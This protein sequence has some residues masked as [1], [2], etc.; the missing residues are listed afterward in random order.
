[1]K[2]TIIALFMALL[3]LSVGLIACS[4]SAEENKE[5]GHVHEYVWE[6][7]R[8]ATCTAE[9]ERTGTCALDGAT[10]TERLEKIAHTPANAVIENSIDATCNIEGSYDEVVY[11]S[12]CGGELSRVKKTVEKIAHTPAAAVIENEVPATTTEKGSYDEVVYCSVCGE[13]LQ[14]ITK[15]TEVLP[16]EEDGEE[17]TYDELKELFN[18]KK[19]APYTKVEIE[20]TEEDTTSTAI[21]V[22]TGGEWEKLEMSDNIVW[23]NDF[24]MY[25]FTFS[26]AALAQ[27]ENID[28]S[29]ML[30]IYK[31]EDGK[32]KLDV[33]MYYEDQ[34]QRDV[35]ILDEFFYVVD[36]ARYINGEPYAFASCVWS[37]EEGEEITY[38]EL[39]ELFDN[40]ET[41]NYIRVDITYADQ[42]GSM[43]P[44]S[45]VFEFIDEEWV[46]SEDPDGVG[47]AE[48]AVSYYIVKEGDLD[49]FENFPAGGTLEILKFSNGNIKITATRVQQGREVFVTFTLDKYFYFLD[50]LQTVN[51][52]KVIEFHG[53]WFSDEG[54]EITF[55]Q[56]TELFDQKE[57]APYKIAYVEAKLP[58]GDYHEATMENKDGVWTVTENPDDFDWGNY[59]DTL[60][61]DREG[62]ADVVVVSEDDELSEETIIRYADGSI[63][64]HTV[65]V[66]TTNGEMQTVVSDLVFDK[67]FHVISCVTTQNDVLMIDTRCGWY[68]TA[69]AEES[70]EI[71]Y[72]EMM[73]LFS[74]KESAPYDQVKI[75]SCR[76]DN[77]DYVY[78][79]ATVELKDGEWIV[80]KSERSPE[81]LGSKADLSDYIVEEGYLTFFKTVPTG[82]YARFYKSANGSVRIEAKIVYGPYESEVIAVMDKYFYVEMT[83]MVDN[84][85]LTQEDTC[86][87]SVK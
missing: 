86:V 26:D 48:D 71:T 2:K 45:A 74:K 83:R 42:M 31:Y 7:T 65:V 53:K 44:H 61:L 46:L 39:K 6:V 27:F 60:I 87:W 12:V 55:D 59:L 51:D 29:D 54:E 18:A 11:C 34:E 16:P 3:A 78:H 22:L 13:E 79:D 72:E 41:P 43:E 81:K 14:R 15:E 67:Y 50:Q 82:G 36:E 56:L 62:L 24:I 66:F 70:I 30:K 8:R 33:T 17:I 76:Y 19:D 68:S 52:E 63:K 20:A 37:V 57:E 47:W 21:F 40:R 80:V 77:G 38:D 84:G 75:D 9:G 28:D 73:E 5:P 58:G 49:M 4:E 25:S 10:K 32:I 23:D 85:R 69:H 64:W 1:M 35:T